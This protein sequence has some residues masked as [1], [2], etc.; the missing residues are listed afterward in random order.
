MLVARLVAQVTDGMTDLVVD[1]I[2]PI[3]T[4]VTFE[5][6]GS[7][8]PARLVDEHPRL[9]IH[10]AERRVVAGR[11]EPEFVATPPRTVVGDTS[12]IRKSGF[13]LSIRTNANCGLWVQPLGLV[14]VWSTIWA[15]ALSPPY[16]VGSRPFSIST[17]YLNTL[18]VP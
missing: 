16:I 9:A 18:T 3:G 2:L 17:V 6:N 1:H 14:N 5:W 12:E 4:Y 10:A 13:P 11:L 8:Y 7:A 15:N